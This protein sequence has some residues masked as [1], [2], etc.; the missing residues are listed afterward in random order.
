VGAQR[1]IDLGDDR[2]GQAFLAEVNDR[3]E[4]VRACLQRLAFAR[5]YFPLRRTPLTR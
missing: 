1:A 4:G 5:I 3:V 2:V